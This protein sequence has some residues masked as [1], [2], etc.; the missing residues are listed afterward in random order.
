M[1]VSHNKGWGAH[2]SPSPDGSRPSQLR[3]HY[4][5]RVVAHACSALLKP[6]RG[7]ESALEVVLRATQ[8]DSV[9]VDRLVDDER[10]GP[11]SR[12]LAEVSRWQGDQTA[13]FS[14]SDPETGETIAGGF[15]YLLA[16]VLFRSLSA[17]V[18]ASV[19]TTRLAEGAEKE[20]FLDMGVTEQYSV[21]LVVDTRW[22][23]SL[24]MRMFGR[25]QRR[26]R[27]DRRLLQVLAK[28]FAAAMEWEMLKERIDA[29]EMARDDLIAGVA[30]QLRTPLTALVGLTEILQEADRLDVAETAALLGDLNRSARDFT[31]V[32]ENLVVTARSDRGMVLVV[33]EPVELRA[34]VDAEVQDVFE[35]SDVEVSVSGGPVFAF[36]DPRRVRLVVRN[37]LLNAL[38][39]GGKQVR[40]RVSL[41]E[42]T[43]I[44]V[45]DDGPGIPQKLVDS[46]FTK[47]ERGVVA[48]NGSPSIGL[49]LTVARRLAW[50]MGGS[51]SYQDGSGTVFI[52][53][54]PT[55]E[56]RVKSIDS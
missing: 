24:G 51:L 42:E 43:T 32:V 27:R 34:L 35:S 39:H 6:D 12:T 50:M 38:Q 54:L 49:G 36:A 53:K 52:L 33:P 5:D 1:R 44:E 25:G 10:F 11:C 41:G 3:S 14:W 2:V 37:L 4:L 48:T 26:R 13:P 16:P 29:L 55:P 8:A 19:D 21:P 56:G 40:V 45:E 20:L 46:I 22:V 47:F 15:P 7:L 30:H 17:G 23:G 9:F 31:H 18:P 28:I